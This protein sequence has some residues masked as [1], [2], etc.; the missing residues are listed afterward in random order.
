[1]KGKKLIIALLSV[2]V[3]TA[4]IAVPAMADFIGTTSVEGTV[5]GSIDVTA[6]SNVSLGTMF[7]GEAT[8]LPAN[9]TVT[10]VCNTGNWTLGARDA[11]DTAEPGH[12]DDLTTALA[13]AL[14][15]RGGD[16]YSWTALNATDVMLEDGTGSVNGTTNITDVN[17]RQFVEY[18]DPP[19]T[20]HIVVTFT[21]ML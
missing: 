6:P 13:D 5:S 3:L 19:G 7:P 4:A 18:T 11:R 17:F 14:E 2:L 8:T 12:M 16:L 21:G 15:I 1:M 10:V 20:Y 9:V